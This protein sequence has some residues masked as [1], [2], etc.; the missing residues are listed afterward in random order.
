MQPTQPGYFQMAD[1]INV[2]SLPQGWDAYAGYVGGKWPTYASLAK[3]F[4]GKRYLSIAV[5]PNEKADCLDVEQGDASPSDVPGWLKG[6]QPGNTP[7]PWI[8]C[9]ADNMA[10]VIA[11]ASAGGYPRTSFYLWSAHYGKGEHVC[12]P[13]T[14]DIMGNHTTPKADGTQWNDTPFDQSTIPTYMFVKQSTTNPQGDTEMPAPLVFTTQ[15][16]GNEQVFFVD[17]SGNLQHAYYRPNQVWSPVEQVTTGWQPSC[18]LA[19]VLY[20]GTEQVWGTLPSGLP[21][22]VYWSGSA[23]VPQPLS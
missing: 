10:N 8:Y 23:W 3:A 17:S 12:G 6:W 2:A 13:R 20:D 7:L 11:A 1:D 5:F 4:P 22:Q 19:H 18:Q 14:C 9:D 21:V 15:F 16:D